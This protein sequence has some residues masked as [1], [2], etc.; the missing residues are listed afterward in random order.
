MNTDGRERKKEGP[1]DFFSSHF[2]LVHLYI[3]A[4]AYYSVE[5]I[6]GGRACVRERPLSADPDRTIH[7]S[8]TSGPAVFLGPLFCLGARTTDPVAADDA[9]LAPWKRRTP[10]YDRRPALFFPTPVLLTSQLAANCVAK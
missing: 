5:R 7:H 3:R 8:A 9:L 6:S 2:F 10:L 4:R 1:D